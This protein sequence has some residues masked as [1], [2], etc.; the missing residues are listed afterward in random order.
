[1]SHFSVAVFTDENTSVKG[2]L[3]PF[4]DSLEEKHSE[5]GG[6]YSSGKLMSKFDYYIIGGIWE[7]TLIIGNGLHV[8]SAKV[9]D[10]RWDLMEKENQNRLKPFEDYLENT[11]HSEEY[12]QKRFPTEEDYIRKFTKFNTYAVLM[13]D[14][15]WIE[16]GKMNW[17]GVW[18]ATPEEETEFE[19]NYEENILNKVKP[20]WRLTIVDCHTY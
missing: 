4:H 18:S 6:I 17:C 1:M 19:R 16:P 10:I 3:A 9:C 5:D 15:N 20:E 8:N 12:I 7:K 11:Y 14:G 13:P 2:L